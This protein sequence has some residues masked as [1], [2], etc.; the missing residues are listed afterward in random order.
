MSAFLTNFAFSIEVDTE[1][2]LDK[3]ESNT[4]INLK[5]ASSD[6]KPVSSSNSKGS[7]RQ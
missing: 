4:R 7:V 6:I 5:G 1:T 3:A 2:C